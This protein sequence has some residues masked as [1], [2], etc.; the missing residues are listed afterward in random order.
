MGEDGDL[1]KWFIEMD[2]GPLGYSLDQLDWY[3]GTPNNTLAATRGGEHERQR[4]ALRLFGQRRRLGSFSKGESAAMDTCNQPRAHAA[5]ALALCISALFSLMTLGY[6]RCRCKSA[7]HSWSDTFH[8]VK[9][10]AKPESTLAALY[11]PDALVYDPDHRG[12][13]TGSF[14]VASTVLNAWHLDTLQTAPMKARFL[15][16]NA[17]EV[18]P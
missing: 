1:G 15:T 14:T 7:L 13:S 10:G 11:D 9:T 3:F 5:H 4:A 16:S 12:F 2:L 8:A 6:V 17:E 18:L